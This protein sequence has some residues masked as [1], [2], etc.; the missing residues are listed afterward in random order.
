MKPLPEIRTNETVVDFARRLEGE[1]Y[2]HLGDCDVCNYDQDSCN[3][4][5][6]DDK[7][8]TPDQHACNCHLGSGYGYRLRELI[9]SMGYSEDTSSGTIVL[10]M[11]HYPRGLAKKFIDEFS[12]KLTKS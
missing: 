11:C 5:D 2:R 3:A 9:K 1:L 6:G 10:P 12:Q 8:C 7:E 4:C